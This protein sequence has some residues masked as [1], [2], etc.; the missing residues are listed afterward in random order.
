MKVSVKCLLLIIPTMKIT[1]RHFYSSTNYLSLLLP[2][3]SVEEPVNSRMLDLRFSKRMFVGT[4]F[5]GRKQDLRLISLTFLFFVFTYIPVLERPKSDIF[6]V[7]FSSM[8]IFLAARSLGFFIKA[9]RVF[10]KQDN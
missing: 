4:C 8:S 2:R 10:Q 9:S 5:L 7:L 3:A 1:K 6:S